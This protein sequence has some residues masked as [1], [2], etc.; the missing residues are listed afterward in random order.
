M[1]LLIESLFLFIFF[2]Y[3]RNK[4]VIVARRGKKSKFLQVV[5]TQSKMVPWWHTLNYHQE[6]VCLTSNPTLCMQG[7]K[8]S[9]SIVG[10]LDGNFATYVMAIQF[11]DWSLWVPYSK[12]AIVVFSSHLL[13]FFTTSISCILFMHPLFLIHM[14]KYYKP[15]WSHNLVGYCWRAMLRTKG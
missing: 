5:W 7:P 11:V 9:N 1:V 15:N 12:V 4:L 14:E 8:C 3:F 6:V 2:S 10:L 13:W